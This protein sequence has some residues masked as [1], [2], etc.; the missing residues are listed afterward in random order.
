MMGHLL[1]CSIWYTYRDSVLLEAK[2]RAAS[3][4]LIENQQH[5]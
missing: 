4:K 3:T 5:A 1:Y 2:H